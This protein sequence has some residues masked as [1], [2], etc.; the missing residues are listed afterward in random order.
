V[1]SGNGTC[2][3]AADV[4]PVIKISQKN[5]LMYYHQ[6]PGPGSAGYNF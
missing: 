4:I 3:F 2:N 5:I 1:Q 6:G